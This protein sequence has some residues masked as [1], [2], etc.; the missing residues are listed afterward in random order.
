MPNIQQPAQKSKNVSKLA[1]PQSIA[2]TMIPT[3]RCSATKNAPAIPENIK[4][5][6][7]ANCFGAPALNFSGKQN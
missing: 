1:A 2:E 4:P 3:Q 5:K 6:N 7:A